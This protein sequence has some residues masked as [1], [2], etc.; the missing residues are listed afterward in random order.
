MLSAA[1]SLG[2]V[3][4]ILNAFKDAAASGAQVSIIY[5]AGQRKVKGILKDASTTKGNREAIT[6]EGLHAPRM[7]ELLKMLI[8]NKGEILEREVLFSKIWK[9]NYTEDTRSL[10]VHISWLRKI[11]EKDPVRPKIIRVV[12]GV[13]YQLDL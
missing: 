6:N 1:S 7:A 2:P 4:F 9:T 13:G 5:E 11:V 3:S 10:D 8:Q 12:R